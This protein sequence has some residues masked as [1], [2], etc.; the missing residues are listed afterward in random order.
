MAGPAKRPAVGASRKSLFPSV[1]I[2]FAGASAFVGFEVTA[3]RLV[4]FVFGKPG[5]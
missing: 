1:R 5:L 4:L 3:G 2:Q